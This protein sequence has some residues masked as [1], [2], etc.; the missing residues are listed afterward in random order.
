MKVLDA[1]LCQ[2]DESFERYAN[3]SDVIH[4]ALGH[5]LPS[6]LMFQDMGLEHTSTAAAN[7]DGNRRSFPQSASVTVCRAVTAT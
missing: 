5:K 4:D 2:L 6:A 1:V 3:R 7:V